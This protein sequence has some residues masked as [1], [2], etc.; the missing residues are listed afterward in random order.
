MSEIATQVKH[1]L[2]KGQLG[3][4][5]SLLDLLELST[6]FKND[7]TLLG[8]DPVIRSP[9]KLGDASATAQLLIGAAGAAIWTA[10]TGEKTD[11]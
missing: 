2:L 5:A 7:A 3:A 9:H 6:H 11:I 10:R 1:S 4:L 8:N